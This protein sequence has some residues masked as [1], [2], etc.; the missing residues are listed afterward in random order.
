[1]QTARRLVKGP[2][3][4]K[5]SKKIFAHRKVKLR[6]KSIKKGTAQKIDELCERFA[7]DFSKNS[8]DIGRT[9]LIRMDIDTRGHP[10]ICQKPYMLALKHYNWV[11]KEVEQ[12]ERTGFIT[13]SVSPWASPIV[14]IPKKSAPNKP[15]RRRM[16]IYFWT[17]GQKQH[18]LHHL[19][20]TSFYK[21]HLV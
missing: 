19:V 21:F 11:E 6:S 10:P 9:N 4:A 15:P 7:E 14:I 13:R 18:L 12:L 1:M 3:T 8:A 17:L 2:D 20:S 16:C 5:T